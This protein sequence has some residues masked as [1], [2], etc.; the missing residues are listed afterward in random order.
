MIFGSRAMLPADERDEFLKAGYALA[1]IDCRLAPE[2][3][4]PEILKDVDDA[5]RWVHEKGPGLFGADPQHIAMTGQSA[6]AYLPLIAGVRGRA[7]P[8]AIVS[9]H[10][11]GNISG[12]WYSRP[13]VFYLRQPRVTKEAAVKVL[14]KRVISESPIQ[15]REEFYV[16]CRQYG[17]WP[18]EVAGINSHTKARRLRALN[19]EDL[20]TRSYPSTLLLQGDQDTDVPFEMS[21]RMEEALTRQG[22]EHRLYRMVGFDHLFDVF[23]Q[24]LPPKGSPIGLQDPKGCASVSCCDVVPCKVYETDL[25]TDCWAVIRKVR[26]PREIARREGTE[27]KR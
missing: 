3:K 6:G 27:D 12:D 25:E 11:Y 7:R 14:S 5:Y 16:Y 26:R 15:P 4:L 20:V 13:N 18:S 17:L 1:A 21:L 24:G 23:P 19:P 8:Q 9:F 22:V 2:T 10:E